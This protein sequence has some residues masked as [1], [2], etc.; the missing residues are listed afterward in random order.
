MNK[1]NNKEDNVDTMVRD[2]C[3]V[4]PRSKSEV[5]RRLVALIE[6]WYEKGYEDGK[7]K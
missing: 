5:R 6:K 7:L 4:F 1:E 3:S 2:F